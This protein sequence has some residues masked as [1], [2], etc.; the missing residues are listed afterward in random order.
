MKIGVL[1]FSGNVG[2]TTITKTLL[3]PRLKDHHIIAIETIN[4]GAENETKIKGKDFA[5]LQDELLINDNIIVDIGASNIEDTMRLMTQYEGSHEDFDY[6][7]IPSVPNTKQQVDTN[8]TI[9][10]LLE[11]GVKPS[12]IRIIF[13][14]VEDQDKITDEFYT[15]IQMAQLAKIKVPTQGILVSEVYEQLRHHEKSIDEILA[16]TGLREQLKECKDPVEKRKISSLIGTQRLATT[17]KRN[18][19]AIFS[20]LSLK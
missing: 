19:D 3:Q 5:Y 18:L 13:N 15:V 16:L 10:S 7:I 8:E 20:E 11:I 1:N 6:F 17:A 14:M 12:R 2:K 4:D 9:K